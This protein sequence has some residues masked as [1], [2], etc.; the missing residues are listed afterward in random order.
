MK[1][2]SQSVM[3]S[4]PKTL[5]SNKSLSA[6]NNENTL[7]SNVK[8]QSVLKSDEV[9]L[10]TVVKS[11]KAALIS[12]DRST[13]QLSDRATAFLKGKEG[14]IYLSPEKLEQM[15]KVLLRLDKD[16][17][18]TLIDADI[19]DNDDF[20]N[21]AQSLD[22]RQIGQFADVAEALK[23]TPK[24]SKLP[25]LH[26][27]IQKVK[28]FANTL[29]GLDDETRTKV[30]DRA[31]IESQDVVKL[32]LGSSYDKFAVLVAPNASANDLNNFLKV[33]STSD[34]VNATLD[35][36]DSFSE[37]QQ[38][39]LLAVM[40]GSKHSD[41]VI[42]QLKDKPDEVKADFLSFMASTLSKVELPELSGNS[43]PIAATLNY[44]DHTVTTASEMI[45]QT[46]SLLESYDFSADQLKE[47]ASTL[48]TLPTADQRA[49]LTVSQEGF[50]L[51]VG[52][53]RDD[54]KLSL[55]GAEEAIQAI[56]EV[57]GNFQA[58]DLV[59]KSRMG[60]AGS[61]SGDASMYDLKSASD[62]TKDQRNMVEALV[63]DAF[64]SL[65]NQ[66]REVAESGQANATEQSTYT[67]HT[68]VLATNLLQLEAGS[69]DA[70][71]ASLSQLTNSDTPLNQLGDE[72]LSATLSPLYQRTTTLAETDN[73]KSLMA[74]HQ[75]ITSD[76]GAV[77]EEQ[78]WQAGQSAGKKIDQLIESLEGKS[79]QAKQVIIEFFANNNSTQVEND[80]EKVQM[81]KNK[82]DYFDM[83]E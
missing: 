22:D 77:S 15:E 19:I 26:S 45:D 51:L 60:E 64:F 50:A 56:E 30:L 58:R 44:D 47:M 34:D 70:L 2:S 36:L 3:Q 17:Q 71:S 37:T 79:E 42:E 12:S 68:N 5:S 78:F 32:D 74:T 75:E 40:A 59:Y 25:E 55:E 38:S 16:Q 82:S 76:S 29:A 8:Q 66:N 7:A 43:L 52:E 65:K 69:R 54:N 31:S 83:I 4:M 73:I 20:L 39:D 81:E 61:V 9:E 46:L 57:R 62:E 11:K 28:E 67:K 53:S 13:G 48:S 10:G 35:E 6:V 63:A 27:S 14:N 23:T 1:I 80:A 24:Q 21:L 72:L 18:A 33:V 41:R 49:Y